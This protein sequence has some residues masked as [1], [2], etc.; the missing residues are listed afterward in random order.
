MESKSGGNAFHGGVYGYFRNEDL[1]A[2]NAFSQTRPIDRQQMY[3]GT[4]GGAIK[5]NKLFFFG[6]F[7][8]QTA[9]APAGV[10]LTV[11][12]AAEKAGD[13]SALS[14]PIYDPSTSTVGPNGQIVRTP[15]PGNIIPS[16][17][18][19]SA[20]LKR[21]WLTSRTRRYRA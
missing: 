21:P 17:D 12:T 3:G 4:I 18:F 15:F 19:D 7:E 1:D 11:P 14:T 5:K 6:S 13:F 16:S 20:A 8:G 10:V 2:M 9:I